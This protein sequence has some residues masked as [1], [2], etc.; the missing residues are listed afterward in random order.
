MEE[1]AKEILEISVKD[2]GFS[3]R[4]KN[5][6]IVNGIKTLRDLVQYSEK[7]LLKIPYIGPKM[8][9]EVRQILRRFGLSLKRG[10]LPYQHFPD[11]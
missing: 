3:R 5:R 7:K 4:T 2:V 9:E 8:I 10:E 11:F 1:K 6:L